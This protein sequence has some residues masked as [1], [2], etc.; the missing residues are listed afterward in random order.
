MNQYGELMPKK[1]STPQLPPG[2]EDYKALITRIVNERIA[3]IQTDSIQPFFE[4]HEVSVA[5]RREQSVIERNKWTVYYD[6]F[7][8]LICHKKP[9][10]HRSLGM[11]ETCHLRVSSRLKTIRRHLTAEKPEQF[12]DSLELARQALLPSIEK[13]AKRRRGQ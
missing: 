6:E 12:Q 9:S 5:M 4:S 2:A 11:C 13:L 3:E 1:S 7:G 8:C 10:R